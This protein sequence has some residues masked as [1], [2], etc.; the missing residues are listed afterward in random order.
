MWCSTCSPHALV[1]IPVMMHSPCALPK[2]EQAPL[3]PCLRP[4]QTKSNV[5]G[6]WPHPAPQWL[7][8]LLHWSSARRLIL[9]CHWST[10]AQSR[11]NHA[12]SLLCR[13]TD[14]STDLEN[15]QPCLQSFS[16]NPLLGPFSLLL[17][18]T[19]HDMVPP[20]RFAHEKVDRSV[21]HAPSVLIPRKA[22]C[23]F[24]SLQHMEAQRSW[25]ALGRA[26]R[27]H[28]ACQ[29]TEEVAGACLCICPGRGAFWVAVGRWNA[30][31]SRIVAPGLN[32]MLR[33]RFQLIT[34]LKEMKE[35]FGNLEAESN[36]FLTMLG[37]YA[38]PLLLWHHAHTLRPLISHFVYRPMAGEFIG[39]V[40]VEGG[41]GNSD[42]IFTRYVC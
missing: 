28:P 9:P 21:R 14:S 31:W 11:R 32:A 7:L 20:Q 3:L 37:A 34:Q 4:L 26:T 1:T 42:C 40:G 10:A 8:L 18:T 12:Q 6:M 30:R 39:S 5:P 22:R 23:K 38:L 19:I 27:G 41:Q 24:P 15:A 36:P 13:R 17:P 29:R 33:R 25:R 2:Q 35:K 16:C